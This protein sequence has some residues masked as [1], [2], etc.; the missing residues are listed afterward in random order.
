MITG[1][2]A[3]TAALVKEHYDRIAGGRTGADG[4]LALPA[5]AVLAVARR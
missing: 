3:A 2:P 1:L 4:L 5:A